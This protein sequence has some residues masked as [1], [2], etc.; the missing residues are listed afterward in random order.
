[1]LLL[2]CF[3][4]RREITLK[5]DFFEEK[6]VIFM[7]SRT[8]NLISNQFLVVFI[9][10]CSQYICT[11]CGCA[12]KSSTNHNV[13]NVDFV[14]QKNALSIHISYLPNFNGI[15]RLELYGNVQLY[16]TIYNGKCNK[17]LTI[18][19]KARQYFPWEC[20]IHDNDS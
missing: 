9:L 18:K 8:K 19:K 12:E 3:V 16:S 4:Y 5:I 7:F 11:Q 10:N 15:K 6:I 2:F 1:M 20:N 17:F 13:W 14:G